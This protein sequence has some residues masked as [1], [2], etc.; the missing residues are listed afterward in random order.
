MFRFAQFATGRIRRGG[1][2][3]AICEMSSRHMKVGFL[4]S[5]VSR[6]AG[7]LFQ[8]VRGL[9]KSVTCASASA[10]VFGISDEQSAVDLQDWQPLSVETFRPQF[11]AWGYSNQLVPAL[12]GAD[13]DI[14]STH[15][16]MNDVT[17]AGGR[18][19]F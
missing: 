15:G 7:G 10:R 17:E 14:L 12:L 8:S 4:V 16:A 13:L 9:A 18:F 3:G 11:R 5:S 19:Y 1:H 2:D 6:E